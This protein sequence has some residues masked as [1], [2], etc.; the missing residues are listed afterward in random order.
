MHREQPVERAHA[1][2]D[3]VWPM[4]SITG[5]DQRLRETAVAVGDGVLEPW[6]VGSAR[7][8]KEAEQSICE[9]LTS[10]FGR[11]VALERSQVLVDAEERVGP[12]SRTA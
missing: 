4:H 10:C 11:A 2:L 5:D 3:H 12:G 9:L 1:G 7:P 6:P 8:L